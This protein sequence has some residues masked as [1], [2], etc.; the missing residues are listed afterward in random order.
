MNQKNGLPG[1]RL[2]AEIHVKGDAVYASGAW[3]ST[4]LHLLEVALDALPWP[5]MDEIRLEMEAVSQ[6]DTAGAW[7]LYRTIKQLEKKGKSLVVLGLSDQGQELL[8]MMQTK[9]G[10][11]EKL[12]VRKPSGW[13]EGI[14]Q[15]A[16]MVLNEGLNL[17]AFTGEIARAAWQVLCKPFS[18]RWAL[19]VR[20]VVETGYKA[21]PIVGLLSMLLGVV[22]EYQGGVQLKQYG[23][24][25]FIADLVGWS[26]LRELA[27]LMT[28]I[29]V[30]GRTGSAFTA[31]IGT[32]KVTEEVDALRAMAIRPVELLVLPKCLALLIALPLLTV[33]A[34]M[35]GV[36]GGMLMAS[37]Q[38]GIGYATFLNRLGEVITLDTY[39]IG[40]GKAPLFAMMIAT[41]ACYQGFQVR[42]SAE[43]V[44]LRTTLSVV[45]SI[46]AIILVD[47]ILSVVFSRLGI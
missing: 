1:K 6:I 3:T 13:L 40:I 21:L 38:L 35:M 25:I 15:I 7:V 42:R 2:L 28:A 44:G 45:Q 5:A 9:V 47:A 17:L 4:G 10:I 37:T 11:P 18:I 31:Q 14:G 8:E 29:I 43:S 26:M 24:D 27:P 19:I 30:A 46:F 12:S 20:G 22:I 39:L 33:Y 23:A 16:T 41:I 36:F 34:D 32:M